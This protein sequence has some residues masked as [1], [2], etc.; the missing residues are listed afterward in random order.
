[1]VAAAHP[2]ASE[3]GVD[4]LRQGG[5]AVDAAVAAAFAVGVVEPMMSGLGGGGGMTVWMQDDQRAD[6]IDFYAAAGA[7]VDTTLR[8]Y[9]GSRVTPRGVAVPGA[10]AGLLDAH[11]RWGRL[12]REAVLAPA[13][14][15][16]E[17]GFPVHPLLARI[18]AGDSAKLNAYPGAARIF[19][20][21]GKPIRA[22][23]RLVQP[24][25]A[26]TLRRIA[27]EGREGFYQGPVAEEIVR[28]LQEGGNPL[29]V[30]DFASYQA[31]W[32]RP[33]CGQYEGL[34]VLSAPPPQSGMQVIEMLNL[35]EPYD[36]PEL[37]LPTRSP[38]A[39]HILTSAM[40]V[41][42]ADRNA[43]VGDPDASAVPAAGVASTAF[44]RE[45]AELVGGSAVLDTI[46]AGDPI[47]EDQLPPVAACA[48]L[49]PWG[50]S[51]AV[52]GALRGGAEAGDEEG[53]ETTHLSA[54]D[55]WG[56]AVS[57][58]YTQGL[59]FG[60]GTWAA[61]TFLNSG[62]FNFSDSIASP[63]ALAPYRVPASTIAPTL[64]LEGN[65]VRLVVGSP[66]SGRI[67]P[68]VVQTI[69]Y[70]HDYGMGPL[71]ALRMPR[72]YPS[73]SNPGVRVENA[74][75]GTLLAEMQALGYEFEAS[76]ATDMF[77]GGVHVIERRDRRWIGAADP[78]RGGEVR[79]Y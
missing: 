65:R 27:A 61:G 7:T 29:T 38:R 46:P 5:N 48:A 50:P 11:E 66:G 77:F 70:T 37:G 33:V 69:V 24:E 30:D 60:S 23:Q 45:R 17:E 9:E 68:A 10:V 36:L 32:R 6:Y 59:Y 63:N 4:V 26:A 16:A 55:R 57:L 54:V 19:W 43:I 35:L 41:A 67:P 13:I 25:L 20:P 3:A 21:G 47:A 49:Q 14:R 62:M 78:R 1:M 72:I 22:G 42:M 71:E 51:G 18:V 31:R 8:G 75:P 28:V 52:A 39:F 58:T 76:P 15:L 73:P 64:V 53:G 12:P 56:N 74:Y 79:G 44:A 40:R 34:T 2:A